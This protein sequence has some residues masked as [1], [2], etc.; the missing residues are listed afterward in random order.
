MTVGFNDTSAPIDEG[1][2]L[3]AATVART[4]LAK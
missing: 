4:F 2:A 3:V 1:K